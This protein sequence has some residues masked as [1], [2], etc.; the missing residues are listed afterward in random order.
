MEKK[1]LIDHIMAV[2]M[3]ENIMIVTTELKMD[4]DKSLDFLNLLS[5]GYFTTINLYKVANKR[6]NGDRILK[7]RDIKNAKKQNRLDFN[8]N[9]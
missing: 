6:N 4:A 9:L 3:E 2:M 1:E 8:I 7:L 5:K